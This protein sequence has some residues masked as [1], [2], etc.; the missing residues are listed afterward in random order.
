MMFDILIGLITN[1]STFLKIYG[2]AKLL[3]RRNGLNGYW[4]LVG[5]PVEMTKI[6]LIYVICVRWLRISNIYFLTVSLLGRYG[7]YL[8]F[9]LMKMLILWK[10]LLVLCKDWKKIVK[11]L[12]WFILTCEILWYIWI[13][14]NEDEF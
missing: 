12:F 14:I 3:L 4:L 10:L 2:V 7:F 9:P 8:V 6:I 1:K 11:N 13:I 5:F